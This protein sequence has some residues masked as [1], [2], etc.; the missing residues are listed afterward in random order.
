MYIYISFINNTNVRKCFFEKNAVASLL[1]L[2]CTR[3]CFVC[4]YI[5]FLVG[6]FGFASDARRSKWERKNR[7]SVQWQ[8]KVALT[9]TV[10]TIYNKNID[11]SSDHRALCPVA[12][13]QPA[14]T[15]PCDIIANTHPD[16]VSQFG[17][18]VVLPPDGNTIP[19]LCLHPCTWA[20]LVELSYHMAQFR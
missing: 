6:Y 19:K 5:I 16:R 14:S 8:E 3:T 2:S 13:G 4:I 10:N 20:R 7:V 9:V 15:R 18:C 1:P 11:I 12:Y 17:Y